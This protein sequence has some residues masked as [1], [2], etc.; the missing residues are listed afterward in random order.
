MTTNLHLRILIFK[1]GLFFKSF[2]MSLKFY[3]LKLLKH[4]EENSSYWGF[5]S[6]KILLVQILNSSETN[7]LVSLMLGINKCIL[8]KLFN[9]FS[10]PEK[11]DKMNRRNN[12]RGSFNSVRKRYFLPCLYFSEATA[13][14]NHLSLNPSSAVDSAVNSL[15]V[16][17]ADF[18]WETSGLGIHP[19]KGNSIILLW[20]Y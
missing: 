18:D 13:S 20:M 15:Y 14:Q 2:V 9:F 4:M 8:S 19:L 6:A 17:P 10:V 12:K 3:I 5:G 7:W 1:T 11:P 16:P